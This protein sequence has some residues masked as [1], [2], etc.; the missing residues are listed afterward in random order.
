[1]YS[2]VSPMLSDVPFHDGGL[3]QSGQTF[4]G[5]LAEGP[6]RSS[7]LSI[8]IEALRMIDLREFE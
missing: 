1:M 6:G 2:N 7:A 5:L 8:C 4:F 3:D